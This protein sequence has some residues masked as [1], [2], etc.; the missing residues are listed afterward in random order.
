[1]FVFGDTFSHDYTG[2]FEGITSC[3]VSVL[4][5]VEI[6]KISIYR[7]FENRIVASFIPLNEDEIKL[8]APPSCSRATLWCFGGI[9][10]TNPDS[11]G[12]VAEGCVFFQKG[13]SVSNTNLT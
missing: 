7:S 1:M 12:D 5:D 10:E 6:P 8:A 4:L 9:V 2:R 11:D 13:L 3:T